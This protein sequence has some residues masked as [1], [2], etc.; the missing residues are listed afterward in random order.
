[1]VSTLRSL[2]GKDGVSFHTFKLAEDRCAPLVV[3]KL[4]R[5]MPDSVVR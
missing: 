5:V 4:G 1:M 2:D 3:K